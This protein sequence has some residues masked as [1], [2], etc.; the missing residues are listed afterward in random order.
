[1]RSGAR[2]IAIFAIQCLLALS[3][4]AGDGA[5]PAS[6]SKENANADGAASATTTALPNPQAAPTPAPKAQK[7]D[8]YSSTSLRGQGTPGGEL[9]LGFSYVWFNTN[10]GP[11]P[12]K[13]SESFDFLPGGEGS[14][15][16]NINNWFG[17]T[18]EGSGYELH[19]VGGV[20]AQMF[21]FMFGPKFSARHG[22]WTPFIHGLAGGARLTTGTPAPGFVGDTKFFAGSRLPFHQN[23]FAADA[24]LGV[25]F[26]ATRHL[27]IRFFQ[28]D[29]LYTK[30]HDLRDN[31]QNNVRA[32]G[33]IVWRFAFPN[34]PPV[35]HPPTATCSANPTSIQDGSGQT[36][37][38]H[39]DANS[40][41][42]NPLTYAWT[43]TGGT[44]DGTGPDARWTQGS[45][46][47]GSYTATARVDDGYGGSVSCSA[48]IQVTPKPILPPTM[49]CQASTASVPPGQRVQVTATAS[50]PQNFPLTYTWQA[51]GG[52]VVGSGA[53]IQIDT[54]GLAPGHYKVDGQVDN[55]HQKTA[56]CSVEFDVVVPPEVKELEQRLALHSVFFPT[57]Q[58]TVKNPNGGLLASQQRTLLSTASDFKK[59][60]TY[61]PG[62][63][64]HLTGHA[65]PRGNPTYNQALSVRRVERVKNFLVEQGVPAES[66]TVEG[67]GE[68][69]PLTAAEIKQKAEQDQTL[70]PDQKARIVKN[71]RVVALAVSRRVDTTLPTTGQTSERTYPFNAEDVLNLINP[72]GPATA[73][74]PKKAPAK[75]PARKRTAPAPT[76]K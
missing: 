7:A 34:A 12:A 45:A 19:D 16:G 49:S 28:G 62:E 27:A 21:T 3:A 18:A 22:R 76:K 44:V 42:N 2:F 47:P 52:Q 23:A 69:T 41:D 51:S 32:S 63:K 50:D 1:M 65:D 64:L 15:T 31:H 8:K 53:Q 6:N 67:L 46:A 33:G 24:G 57:A 4:F 68:E 35:H 72:R 30:F 17:L 38:V 25:D 56:N 58:P 55:G 75:K 11:K 26:N 43:A 73:P 66:I 60:L 20:S 13:T 40:P 48:N 61:K 14:I 70:T 29:Y 71:A 74:A 5:K 59:Y 10:T 54:T 37:T 36:V 39:A 9:F